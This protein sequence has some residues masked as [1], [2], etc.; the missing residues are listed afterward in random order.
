MAFYFDLEKSKIKQNARVV[1]FVK[2]GYVKF[3]IFLIYL[4]GLASL[5]LIILTSL[6]LFSLAKFEFLIFS[7]FTLFFLFFIS[8]HIYYVGGIKK[9]KLP[10]PLEELKKR[11]ES[12]ERVNLADFLSISAFLVI[13]RALK[14]EKENREV[15]NKIL[16]QLLLKEKRMRFILGRMGIELNQFLA[17]LENFYKEKKFTEPIAELAA[18][19]MEAAYVEYHERIDLGDFLVILAIS[20]PYFSKILFDLNLKPED[21]LNIAYWETIFWLE[22]ERRRFDPERLKLSGGIGKDWAAGYTQLLSRY[23]RDLTREISK[24]GFPLHIIGHTKEIEELEKILIR[25]THHNVLLVGE[26][27]VGKKTIVLGLAKRIAEG[28]T[29]RALSFRHVMELDINFILAGA[30]TPG[31]IVARLSGVLSDAVRAGNIILFID[32]IQALF[33]SGVEG[34]KIGAI[35]ASQIIIPYLEYQGLYFIATTDPASFHQYIESKGAIAE[36]FEKIEIKEP[37]AEAVIRILEDIVPQTEVQTG[38]IFSYEALKSI[39][40]LSDQFLYTKPFPE[41]AIDLLNEVAVYAAGQGKGTMVMAQHVQKV[42]EQKTGVPV[43]EAGRVEKEKLLKLEEILHQR[44]VGQDEAIKAIANAMR[45]A[46]AGVEVS[47][48]PI[49]SFLFLGPT[50][51]GKTETCKALAWSYFGN[52]NAMIRFDMSEYQDIQGIYRLIGAPAGTPEAK[53]GGLLT[54]AVRD[55]PFSLVLLDEI[56]KAHPDILNLFL[57]VLDEGWLTDSLGRKVK[58]NN[59]IIIATSNAGAE[60]IR[61]CLK[62]GLSP[63]DI[64][65][66][67]WDYLQKKGLFRPEFLN[68]F[69]AV[70]TFNPLTP[71][72]VEK[73]TGFLVSK[74]AKNLEEEKG[75]FLEIEGEAIAKLAKI[76]F[77]PMLGARPIQ[78]VIQKKIEDI[79]V[80]KILAGEIKRGDTLRI[81]EEDI[82]EE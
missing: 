32:G 70:V 80:K 12:A 36:K 73:I 56:E 38:V 67:L 37:R 54:S 3:L 19:A 11:R 40:S 27:G 75:I 58:F 68:R 14:K 50:G 6:N 35:D 76:G 81:R 42:I 69:T 2:K 29:Y 13:E 64:G 39:V 10:Y 17:G 55:H 44:V 57:Q 51:V 43:G 60:L 23:A 41:K 49:G 33:G 18:K 61:E 47:K 82:L 30:E 45:R 74:L 15:D 16:L 65:K 72:E 7:F 78:R 5:A 4:I 22:K 77:D 59:T 25:A 1:A 79:L 9:P 62:E 63:S 31:E 71:L 66:K 20:D 34:S 52:E 24:L 21:I 46:R 28:Q 48:K 8:C 53:A 26:A